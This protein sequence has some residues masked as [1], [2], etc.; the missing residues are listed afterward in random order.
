MT[1]PILVSVP[2]AGHDVPDE[3]AEQCL[4]S[5]EQII[6]DGDEFASEL[7]DISTSC[8]EFI[9]TKIAR[10]FVDLNRAPND[11]RVDGVVK[12]HTIWNESI[13]RTPLS[14]RSVDSLLQAHYFPYH[15]RLKEFAEHG[16]LFA[17]DCHTMAAF[18]P[19][20]GPDPGEKRPEICLGNVN[21]RSFS[22]E[23]TELIFQ[24]FVESFPEFQ[25]T[26]NKPF[27]GGYITQIHGREM[28][29]IQLEISRSQ[30]L[31]NSDVKSRVLDALSMTCTQIMK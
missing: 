8:A 30:F 24:S 16:L 12:T 25:V 13:Y 6:R 11:R 18:G 22:Q 27:S 29:W 5:Q 15:Q 4:L 19:P 1:L 14:E 28:P 2:H 23:W 31:A 7:F 17:V 9:T 21:A 26:I 10:A 3:I 20:I